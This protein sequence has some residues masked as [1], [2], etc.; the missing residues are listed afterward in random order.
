[1]VYI[2][3]VGR[4]VLRFRVRLIEARSLQSELTTAPVDNF[5]EQKMRFVWNIPGNV[6]SVE[7]VL[8]LVSGIFILIF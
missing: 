6:K 7:I 2:A 3:P 4:V 5:I 8:K 1:M